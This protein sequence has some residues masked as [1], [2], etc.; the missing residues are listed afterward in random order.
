MTQEET[1]LKELP[2]GQTVGG[3][4]GVRLRVLAVGSELLPSAMAAIP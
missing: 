2:E 4:A 3:R 1:E